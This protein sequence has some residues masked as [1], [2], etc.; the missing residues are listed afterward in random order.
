MYNM[1]IRH[2]YNLQS[3]FLEKTIKTSQVQDISYSF[4]TV[5]CFSVSD[6]V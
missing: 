2:L 4:V 3:D 1:V 5:K 6:A